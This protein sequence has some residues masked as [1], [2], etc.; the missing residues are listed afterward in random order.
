MKNDKSVAEI[1]EVNKKVPCEKPV[2][3]QI[4]I[5]AVLYRHPSRKRLLLDRAKRDGVP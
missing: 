2:H 3:Q 4:D 5:M 1:V